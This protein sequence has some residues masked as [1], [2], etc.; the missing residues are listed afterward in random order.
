MDIH[1]EWNEN[2]KKEGSSVG[3]IAQE[4]E[5][6]FPELTSVQANGY[7]GVQYDKLVPLLIESIKDQQKQIVSLKER[8]DT[9]EKK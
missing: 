9:L 3:V 2:T 8:I 7:K 4:V 1:S 6:V 5:S